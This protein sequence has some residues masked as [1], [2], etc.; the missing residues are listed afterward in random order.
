MHGKK[1]DK[2]CITL[3][4]IVNATGTES[5]PIMFIGHYAKPR[6]FGKIGPNKRGF[7]YHN[8]KTAW[9]TS[10]LYEEC[11]K[12]L[13][14]HFGR[15]G[16]KVILWSDNFSGHDITYEPK[17]I[18]LERFEPNLTLFIQPLDQGII[19]AFKAYFRKLFCLRAVECDEA[20]ERDVY[21]ID[22]LEALRMATKAWS[23]ITEKTIVNC[24]R[25][26]GI[27]ATRTEQDMCQRDEELEL[28]AWRI[29]RDFARKKAEGWL[30]ELYEGDFRVEYDVS[31]WEVMINRITELEPDDEVSEQHIL[32]IINTHLVPIPTSSNSQPNPPSHNTDLDEVEADLLK[33]VE[34]LKT[35]KRIFGQLPTINELV[36]PLEE[37]GDGNDE[38]RFGDNAEEQIVER[39][40]YK[41]A[42]RRGR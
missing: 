29:L 24:W 9:Q 21:A 20:G 14:L 28:R 4:F 27:I 37:K 33:I 15:E 30:Q 12:A 31:K 16:R 7:Y 26:A 1:Q 10:E 32:E 35:Q 22:M 3:H 17:N 19:R 8:N 18:C 6:C 23:M 41:E 5:Y 13:D 36:D 40:K 42:V 34:D 38:F 11:I 25:K 2:T 39:V